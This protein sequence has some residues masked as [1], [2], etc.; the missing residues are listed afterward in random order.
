MAIGKGIN[1]RNI[2]VNSATATI[3]SNED[4]NWNVK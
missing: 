1:P 3:G 2:S 4:P